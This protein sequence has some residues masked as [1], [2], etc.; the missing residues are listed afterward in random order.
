MKRI[1][2]LFAA[3]GLALLAFAADAAPTRTSAVQPYPAPT[4][5]FRTI[6]GKEIGPKDFAGKVVLVDFWATWCGYCAKSR[7]E[8]EAITQ[9][10]SGKPFARISISA[11]S[12]EEPVRRFLT[13]HPPMS[14][15]VWD[16][17]GQLSAQFNVQGLPTH[18]LIDPEGRVVYTLYGWRDGYGPDLDR[19]IT[20]ELGKLAAGRSKA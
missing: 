9:R 2:A 7:P 15:Q 6:D 20:A 19:A 13:Q 1:Y 10:L 8:V 11:D 16:G 3:C 5:Q 14:H 4:L 12:S 18:L 17:R